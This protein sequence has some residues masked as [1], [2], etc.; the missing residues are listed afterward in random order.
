MFLGLAHRK[1]RDVRSLG[2][3]VMVACVLVA[4]SL[5]FVVNVPELAFACTPHS[6]IEI[7]ADSQFTYGNGVTS[8]SGTESDPYII[9]GWE[10]RTA[11]ENGIRI[12][13]T[14]AYFVVRNVRVSFEN[15]EQTGG[16]YGI[17]LDHVS[18]GTVEGARVSNHTS[19]IY[20]EM[21]NNI[22]I[23]GNFLT[24][25]LY[26]ITTYLSNDSEICRNYVASN[27]YEG[28]HIWYSHR[29]KIY[30]NN[31][32]D[33][34]LQAA[35]GGTEGSTVS[36]DS[37]YPGGGNYWDDHTGP[38]KRSGPN[39]DQRG[40]D[41]IVDEPYTISVFDQDRYPLVRP[42]PGAFVELERDHTIYMIIAGIVAAAAV[43]VVVVL[44]WRRLRAPSPPKVTAEPSPPPQ[45]LFPVAAVSGSGLDLAKQNVLYSIRAR[46]ETDLPVSRWWVV[47]PSLMIVVYFVLAAYVVAGFQEETDT[48]S[49]FVWLA[50][51]SGISTTMLG[52][53][54]ILF[55]VLAYTLLD[56]QNNHCKREE[57]LRLSLV[58]YLVMA[59]GPSSASTI[60]SQVGAMTDLHRRAVSEEKR[61]SPLAWFLIVFLTPI[62]LAGAFSA[63]LFTLTYLDV[64]G[65]WSGVSF[66]LFYPL[67]AALPQ[68]VFL[69]K[70]GL[71]DHDVRLREFGEHLNKAVALIGSEAGA[72]YS[73]ASKK[74]PTVVFLVLSFLTL[75]L[76]ILAWWY[77]AVRDFDRHLSNQREFENKIAAAM[78]G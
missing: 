35:T 51:A 26:G 30:H 75:G 70:I 20:L 7:Q 61:R 4:A 73:S 52:I 17:L 37:G 39:Q 76:F 55:A 3:A 25:N 44:L 58:Q 50:M 41:G 42:V 34:P 10:I 71:N 48:R 67:G 56:R 66:I 59:S 74:R 1:G 57:Q 62:L 11:W 8:G 19:G 29:L 2:R 12:Y 15:T 22:T 27:R 13:N 49:D 16:F 32:V 5:V 53:T 63:V 69:F 54:V 14:T 68:L 38:D 60:S 31:I 64:L 18:N 24:K 23:L 28:L 45:R 33:N 6:A 43:T 46:D 78:T 40:S 72:S 47:V 9:E 21:S 77:M 65:N 36:W